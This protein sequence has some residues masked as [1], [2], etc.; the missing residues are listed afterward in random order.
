MGV[1]HILEGGDDIK[2][3]PRG[4]GLLKKSFLNGA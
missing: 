1:S 4:Q 2:K 3:F